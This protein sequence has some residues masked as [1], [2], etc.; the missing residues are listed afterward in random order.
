MPWREVSTVSQRYELVSLAD[1]PDGNVRELCRRYQVSPKTAYKWLARFR[2]EGVSGL[3]DRS[4]QPLNS[5]LRTPPTVERRVLEIRREHPAWGGRKIRARLL[6]T[7]VQDVPCAS[8]VTAVLRRHGLL[9]PKES[10]KHKAFVRFEHSQ[11]NDLWQM[12]FKGHFAL[13]SGRCHP[14]TILDDHSRFNVVLQACGD[15]RDPTVRKPLIGAFRRYGLPRRI[16]ADNGAP[17][18]SDY[19]H[20]YTELTVWLLRLGVKTSHSRPYHPQTQGK[21]ERFHRT[22]TVEV[23]R[24]RVFRDLDECQRSFERWRDVYNLERPHEALGQAVPASRYQPSPRHFPEALPPLEYAPGDLVRKV[25]Q[26][27]YL[28]FHGKTFKFG[29]AFI[30]QHVALRPTTTD[31]V[32]DVYYCQEQIAQIDL[33]AP[34]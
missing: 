6:A 32:W 12:D 11:P 19:E 13:E 1:G 29:R 23:L 8:T 31:G 24:N 26:P 3:R 17:W 25:Y 18:G 21:D 10:E 16:L 9:D 5:P 7:G 28:D 33:S 27:G 30:G 22:L 20:R 4:R 34:C 2:S 15:E 14:L